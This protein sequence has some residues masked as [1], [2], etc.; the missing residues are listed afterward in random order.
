MS[1]IR[2]LYLL[3]ML[4]IFCGF[5]GGALIMGI[6]Y[7]IGMDPQHWQEAV[8]E[9]AGIGLRNSAR[10]FALLNNFTSFLLPALICAWI[11]AKKGWFNYLKLNVFSKPSNLLLSVLILLVSI[12]LVQY[13]YSINR[14][15]PLPEWMTE[16]ESSTE[17]FIRGLLKTDYSYEFWLNM[18]LFAVIPALGEELFFRGMMQQLF[19]KIFRNP[20][21]AIWCTAFVF[22]AIH[23]QFQ[24]FIPRFLLGGILGYVFYLT[25]SLWMSVLGHF[26]NNALMVISAHLFAKGQ[27]SVD[28]EKQEFPWQAGMAS[29]VLTIFIL[30]LL[31][32]VN[33]NRIETTEDVSS[34]NS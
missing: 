34:G 33:A 22:S 17:V 15:L 14:Q 16:I 6:Q 23:F 10:L 19:Q 26:T 28:L 25:G 29:L 18:L 8:N 3:F 20:Q 13:T 27:L 12:P 31:E 9:S 5:M 11:V 24:G 1:P 21:V 4:F 30:Y 32:K 2:N 7:L